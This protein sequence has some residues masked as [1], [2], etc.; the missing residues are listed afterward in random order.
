M[1]VYC[2]DCRF[3]E[4]TKNQGP[5]CNCSKNKVESNEWQR[6]YSPTVSES[7]A[8]INKNNDCQW[9]ERKVKL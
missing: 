4:D 6:W 8:E 2:K 5:R 1:K 7:P 3:I 9:F